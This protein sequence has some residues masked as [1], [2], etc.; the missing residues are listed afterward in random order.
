MGKSWLHKLGFIFRLRYDNGIR[1]EPIAAEGKH[2]DPEFHAFAVKLRRLHREIIT[3]ERLSD[4]DADLASEALLTWAAWK[5]AKDWIRERK[6]DAA[7]AQR[8][9]GAGAWLW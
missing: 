8:L 2:Q 6:I 4:E 9:K 7:E 5:L 3:S 1:F